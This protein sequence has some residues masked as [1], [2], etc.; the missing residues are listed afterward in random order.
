MPRPQRR[1]GR[2]TPRG[3]RPA[4]RVRQQRGQRAPSLPDQVRAALREPS[5]LGLLT[6]ASTFVELCTARPTDVLDDA[7]EA[8]R[9]LDDVVGTFIG[10]GQHEMIVLARCMALLAGRSDL[11]AQAELPAPGPSAANRWLTAID[12]WLPNGTGSLTDELDDGENVFVG[13]AWPDGAAAT[14]VVY[15]D[16]NMGTLV[17][18]AF[19]IPVTFDEVMAQYRTIIEPGQQVA[20]LAPADARARLVEALVQNDRTLPPI[21]TDSWPSCRPLAEWVLHRL[22]FGGAGFTRAVWSDADLDALA[23]ELAGSPDGAVTGLTTDEVATIVRPLLRL[24]TQYA[25]GDPLRWSAVAVEIALMGAPW[26][27][28]D[29]PPALQARLPDVL[30]AL[31]RIAHQRRGVSADATMLALSS[32]G[33]WTPA[34]LASLGS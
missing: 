13:V 20:E 9:D 21:V 12:E 19:V 11:V 17:K 8:K 29:L 31:V 5:P 16:H 27:P 10:S 14:F 15:V 32:V 24:A 7:A 3:T 18:D 30:E 28:A 23:G 4:D 6:L 25:H 1:S 2:V 26:V 33:Q 34:Y 22:P